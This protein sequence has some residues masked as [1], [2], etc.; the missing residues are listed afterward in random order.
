MASSTI[1]LPSRWFVA[2]S[3]TSSS[4]S[5]TSSPNDA[6]IQAQ[7][8]G[9]YFRIS[10]ALGAT[11][12]LNDALAAVRKTLPI[13]QKLASAST[14]PEL[15]DHF[16][17][18]H[19]FIAGLLIQ[20]GNAAGALENYRRASAIRDAALQK[21]PANA[22]LRTHLVADYIG[23]AGCMSSLGDLATAMEMQAKA[24]ELTRA[25][26][27]TSPESVTLREYSEKP[28]SS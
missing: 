28:S 7:L 17:G 6:K 10:H 22:N 3:T 16:A 9:N 13:T 21:C 24:V 25:L 27:R 2:A 8:S 20:T 18:S 23:M 12:D 1:R 26:S 15:A 11:G 5:A 4:W 19:Y 14:D